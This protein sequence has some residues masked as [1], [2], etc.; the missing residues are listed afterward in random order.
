[1]SDLRFPDQNVVIPQDSRSFQIEKDVEAIT[2]EMNAT[3]LR[4]NA[5]TWLKNVTKK[6]EESDAATEKCRQI[7]GDPKFRPNASADLA[8]QFYAVRGHQAT[9]KTKRGGDS[10]DKEVIS[11][12]AG[13]GDELA[14]AVQPARRLIYELGQLKKWEEFAKAGA[15]RPNFDQFGTPMAR[16][17]CENPALQNRIVEIRETIEPAQGYTFLSLDMAQAEYVVWASLSQDPILSMAFID[18]TDFHQMMWD[19]IADAVDASLLRE[20]GRPAGKMVNF[21][22]L[23]L[24]QKFALAPR[25]GTSQEIAEALIQKWESRAVH[26]VKFRDSFIDSAVKAGRTSTHFGRMRFF[27]GVSALRDGSEKHEIVKTMWHHLISGTAAELM[28][29]K[30]KRIRDALREKDLRKTTYFSINMHD[31]I[32]L[33][34]KDEE[35]E[36]VKEV[37]TEAFS[38]DHEG[39]LPF[40]VTVKT[41]KNWLETSK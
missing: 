11:A 21:A 12:I 2:A 14:L 5:A 23:Y 3:G 22:L 19:Q 31:E 10:M 33:Q 15:C 24:M 4:V 36:A 40:A 26:A 28:K 9:R 6:K 35:L 30:M 8:H 41:G 29:I 20:A 25:L 13:K 27:A 7:C 1:M 17:T 16:Y 37:A 34:V 39:F 38:R 32:I 18:G